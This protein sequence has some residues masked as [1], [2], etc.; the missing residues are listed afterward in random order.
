MSDEL[1]KSIEYAAAYEEWVKNP[2]TKIFQEQLTERLQNS[3][4]LLLS[5][6]SSEQIF[7]TQGACGELQIILTLPELIYG[8]LLSQIKEGE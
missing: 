2:F 1:Q 7:R 3:L 4:N 6:D 8:N 5:L